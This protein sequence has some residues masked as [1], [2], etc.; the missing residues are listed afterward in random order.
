MRLSVV[1]NSSTEGFSRNDIRNKL[2]R[3]QKEQQINL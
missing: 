1:L 3:Q 2:L